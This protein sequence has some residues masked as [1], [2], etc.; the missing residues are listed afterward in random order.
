MN[1]GYKDLKGEGRASSNVTIIF[2]TKYNFIIHA[3]SF[4]SWQVFKRKKRN[5]FCNESGERVYVRILFSIV[6]L[7]NK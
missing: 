2:Y 7:E 3:Q 1:P 5:V 4:W 6:Y